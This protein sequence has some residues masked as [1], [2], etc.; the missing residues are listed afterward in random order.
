MTL[1]RHA[2][3]RTVVALACAVALVHLQWWSALRDGRWLPQAYAQASVNSTLAIVVVPQTKKQQEEAE[4]IERLL[5][6]GAL[7]IENVQLFELS[8]VP[9]AAQ[10]VKAAEYVE[11]ALRALLLRTPKRAQDRLAAA[12]EALANAPMAADERLYARALKAQAMVHLAGN[13]LIKA[14]ESLVKSLV[15][16]PTQT[17]EEYS[18]YGSAAR[19]LFDA[20]KPVFDALPRGEMKV[21][22]KGGKTAEVWVDGQYRGPAPVSLA[23]LAAGVHRITVRASGHM[24]DRRFVE[25]IAGK[26]ALAEVE[27]KQAAF[28]P[29]LEQ[30]R[31]VLTAN[32]LQP[33]MVEDRMRELRNQLGADQMV[34]VR[35]KLS[36]QKTELTGYFLTADGNLRKIEVS[37]PKDE[38]YFDN[39]AK[40]LADTLGAKL[41]ADVLSQPL[42]ARPTVVQTGSQRSAAIVGGDDGIFKDDKQ[43]TDPITR[44]WWFWTAVGGGAAVIGGG[45]F[46]LLSQDAAKATGATGDVTLQMQY[47]H[48]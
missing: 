46:L 35:P 42:D 37:V 1:F 7:R 27:L 33:N 43:K 40:L 31:T 4:A 15:M 9:A 16:F 17:A 5:D 20:T 44:K 21:T 10:G 6:D 29:E 26:P 25:V 36:K 14:R 18:A 19:E 3:V 38:K 24:A 32:F 12:M 13:E 8:P 41:M 47:L 22:I 34:L 11:E 28:G 45:I 30:G 48:N 39:L 23:N 2:A